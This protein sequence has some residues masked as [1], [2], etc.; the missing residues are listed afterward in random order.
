MIKDLSAKVISGRAMELSHKSQVG[1][2]RM[3]VVGNRVLGGW[4][5]Y[6]LARLHDLN[7]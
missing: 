7:I 4:R 1:K 2:R 5:S 6:R 3:L